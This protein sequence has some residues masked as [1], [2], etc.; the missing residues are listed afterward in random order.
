VKRFVFL[1]TVT[2]ILLAALPRATVAASFTDLSGHW[3]ADEVLRASAEGWVSGYP[4]GTF[5]PDAP[6]SRA[7]FVKMLT[8]ATRLTP[9]SETVQALVQ[10]AAPYL[11][12]GSTFGL[13]DL[14]NH[15]LHL[16]GWL[17]PAVAFGLVVPSD[18]EGGI[19]H[20]DSPITRQEMAVMT[21]RAQGL[22]RAAIEEKAGDLGFRDQGEI[23]L[24]ARGYVSQAV[25]AGILKGY[26]DG[27]FRGR[28]S[29][30]RAEA[31]VMVRRT[32]ASMAEGV[33][34]SL[35]VWV[36]VAADQSPVPVNLSTPVR[37]ING[38]VYVPARE[39]FR[40]IK[41]LT[42]EQ[43]QPGS[44]SLVPLAVHQWNP[45]VQEFRYGLIFA[46]GSTAAY[47]PLEVGVLRRELVAPARI[48]Y[49]ELLLPVRLTTPDDS[50]F[51][52]VGRIFWEPDF[53]RVIIYA[54]IPYGT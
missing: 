34:P 26:P 44:G 42:A 53:R 3:A 24:W 31:V 30:T 22:A 27:T 14:P 13:K 9:G 6:I 54:V 49:G 48:A 52:K 21:V 47:E 29:A 17:Q 16:Q 1:L 43:Q 20:P 37:F 46:A 4:D 12:A 19:F 18:Y 50:P 36:K 39:V 15:W 41:Q 35:Q 33:D 45:T 11:P 32:V 10:A 40:T 5:R 23:P 8:A 38:R 25:Q 51:Y 7:E 2:L 28:Q